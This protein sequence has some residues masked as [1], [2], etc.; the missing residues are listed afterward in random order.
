MNLRLKIMVLGL[1]A[2]LAWAAAAF[3]SLRLNPEIR[4]YLGLSGI[5]QAWADHLRSATGSQF[6]L[7]GGS[8]ALFSV[9]PERAWGQ[10]R[11]PLV[12]FGLAAAI[13]PQVMVLRGLGQAQSG[14]TLLLGMEPALL[15]GGGKPGGLGIQYSLAMAKPGW[16]CDPQ[17]GI[18]AMSWG[19]ALLGL[20][21]GG[22]H[23]VTLAGKLL[24]R[25]PL[26][27]YQLQDVSQGGWVRTEVRDFED[28]APGH[29]PELS[30]WSVGMLGALMQ[31]AK[32]RQI[33]LVYVLPWAYCPLRQAGKFRQENIRFLLQIEEFMPVLLDPRLGAI[34]DKGLFADSSWH[35]NREGSKQRTD[36]LAAQLRSLRSWGRADLERLAAER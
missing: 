4:F 13:E 3:Y 30:A 28:N 16:I 35:L 14:D 23:M 12:N 15:T 8:S 26:Y 33:Q 11:V 36:E 7:I 6:I 2:F 19:S 21:P 5:Q 31:Q 24:L 27:R 1:V 34:H 17:L 22:Y 32:E 9:M 10:D 20:R 18:S 29:G 25:M